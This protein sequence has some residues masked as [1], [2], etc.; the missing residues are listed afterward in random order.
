MAPPEAEARAASRTLPRA[1]VSAMQIEAMDRELGRTQDRMS[2]S[3]KRV[4]D[5]QA[6]ISKANAQEAERERQEIQGAEAV[7]AQQKAAVCLQRL[8]RGCITRGFMKRTIAARYEAYLLDRSR[9]AMEQRRLSERH[10]MHAKQFDGEDRVRAA[11]VIQTWWRGVLGLRV[12]RMVQIH[13]RML[14]VWIG[15]HQAAV[16][17]QA[18]SRGSAGRALY[19]RRLDEREARLRAKEEEEVRRNFHCVVSIQSAFRRSSAQKEVQKRRTIVQ[20]ELE[21]ISEETT[22]SPQLHADHPHPI[23]PRR[24]TAPDSRRRQSLDGPRAST[25]VSHNPS[26]IS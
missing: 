23:M 21:G 3:H 8:A 18:M 17:L 4:V 6:R 19:R 12:A 10:E 15:V 5:L 22:S 16:K 2:R 14:V 20:R 26:R 9:V 1:R 7:A 25:A 13:Q 24:N 11:T